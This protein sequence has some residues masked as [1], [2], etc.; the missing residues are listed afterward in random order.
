MKYNILALMVLSSIINFRV[1]A[2]D[3]V[4]VLISENA[5]MEKNNEAI[6]EQT[7][8][9]SDSLRELN[10]KNKNDVEALA[11]SIEFE[12]YSISETS[13]IHTIFMSGSGVCK[14]YRGRGVDV[15]DSTTYYFNELSH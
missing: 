6:L 13:Q 4:S 14:G 15:T 5:V 10:P 1:V 12:V 3:M 8:V 7:Y 2:S 11:D 9:V